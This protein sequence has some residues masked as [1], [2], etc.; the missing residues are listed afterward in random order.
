MCRQPDSAG[1]GHAQQPS[2][3]LALEVFF[4]VRM[5]VREGEDSGF[6]QALGAGPPPSI[7]RMRTRKNTVG[8]RDYSAS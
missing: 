6:P 3:W 1:V 2:L 7:T 5:R 8:L 4:R